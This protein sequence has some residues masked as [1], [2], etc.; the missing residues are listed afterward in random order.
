M[1]AIIDKE[2]A[3]TIYN[4][5]SQIETTEEIISQL[6]EFIQ[7]YNE[8][9]PP[10]V[11]PDNYTAYGSIEISIPYFEAGQFEKGGARVFNISYPA[12]MK[13]LKSHVRCIKNKLK[14]ELSEVE[15]NF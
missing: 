14:K 8:G 12:A 1:N 11:I 15:I 10:P 5:Y 4:L 9:N 7:K 3:R 13:V 6:K 2:K